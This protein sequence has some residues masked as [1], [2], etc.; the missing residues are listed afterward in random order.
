MWSDPD[1]IRLIT[2]K[3][4]TEPQTWSRLLSYVGHWDLMGFGYWA[5]EEKRSGEFAGEAGLA[6]FKRDI[7]QSMRGFPEI[8]FALASHFHGKGYATEAVQ[9]IL[10]WA[11]VELPVPKTVCLI[12]P[13]N[14]ASLHVVQKCGYEIFEQG[15]YNGQPALF[16]SRDRCHG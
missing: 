8:G 14:A 3:P 4:S 12:N 13:Q 10:A 9:A 6:D 2:G 16:L 7:A 11:D 5:I 15:I 1:V